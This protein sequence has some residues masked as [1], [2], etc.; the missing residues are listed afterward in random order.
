MQE[1][2]IASSQL[3]RFTRQRG[4]FVHEQCEVDMATAFMETAAQA[5]KAVDARKFHAQYRK[6]ALHQLPLRAGDL[7]VSDAAPPD[8]FLPALAHVTIRISS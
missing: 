2:T 8:A 1:L 4:F 6:Q 3:Q 7:L 5:I